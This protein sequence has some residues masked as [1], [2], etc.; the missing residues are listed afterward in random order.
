M[1]PSGWRGSELARPGVAALAGDLDPHHRLLEGHLGALEVGLGVAAAHPAERPVARLLR[2]IQIDLLGALADLRQDAD[3]RRQH[4][5]EA[6]GY[7]QIVP[8]VPPAVD[9][10]ADPETGQERRV[11]G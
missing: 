4:L 7:R 1:L 9:E 10:L 8:H 2:P 11:A 6:G 5:G 3:P